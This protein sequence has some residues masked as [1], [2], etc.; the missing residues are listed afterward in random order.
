[1]ERG[2][3]TAAGP[4][5]LLQALLEGAGG[6]SR[7]LLVAELWERE[8]SRSLMRDFA[9]HVFPEPREEGEEEEEEEEEEAEDEE[10]EEEE[11]EEEEARAA[12]SKPGGPQEAEAGE[13]SGKPGG[14]Q[15][16][17]AARAPGRGPPE[18]A[19]RSPLVFVLCREASLRAPEP[20][21]R[22]REILRDVRA[23]RR[24][25]PR[26][27]PRGRLPPWGHAGDCGG[28]GG[29]ALVGVLV[30][31]PG[32][33][34][35]NNQSAEEGSEAEAM[36]LLEALLRSVFGRDSGGPVQAASY[37]PV[38]PSSA[39]DVQSAACRAL[40]AA[41]GQRPPGQPG[42][43]PG[44]QAGRG[45]KEGRAREGVPEPACRAALLLQ[46]RKLRPSQR[47]GVD[48]PK[49]TRL[50]SG[51]GT[52]LQWGILSPARTAGPG[53]WQ[54]PL[55]VSQEPPP[56]APGAPSPCPRSPLPV[57]QE[58]PSPCLSSDPLP[59]PPPFSVL[60]GWSPGRFWGR[61]TGCCFLGEW[62][63]ERENAF[64]ENEKVIQ[65]LGTGFTPSLKAEEG[66]D[67]FCLAP[68][69][70]FQDPSEELALTVLSPNGR[71]DDVE[72]RTGA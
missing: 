1:M 61:G 57:S 47:G 66:A 70:G 42:Q 6:R 15:E 48:L 23:R 36:H 35:G 63:G 17:A 53:L 11:E 16:A 5:N 8:Q 38:R 56:H 41:A 55:P 44:E 21:L 24:Q 30:E 54:S 51:R 25:R 9:R 40:R 10:K 20:R 71:C 60:L 69:D 22:L 4:G 39:A 72:G 31:E 34:R 43:G 62:E 7:V 49:V 27:R 14:P 2:V 65:W 68:E 19:I 37:C 13:A 45:A 32:G 18:R 52:H 50:E 28:G 26:W 3:A 59:L 29:A 12:G 64:S 58:P 33:G 46:R 67:L